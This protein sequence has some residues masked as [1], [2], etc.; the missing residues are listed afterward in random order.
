MTLQFDAPI[1][2]DARAACTIRRGTPADAE[3]LSAFAARTFSDTYGRYNDPENL[4]R[5]IAAAFHPERQADEL[6]DPAV[7]TLLAHCDDT[8][9]G[10]AQVRRSEAPACVAHEAPVELHRF[11][12]DAAW[13]GCGIAQRL[14][15]E[16]CIAARAFG[17]AVL[18]LKVWEHNARA[19]AF[20]AKSR[21]IDVGTADFQ[22][23]DDR[24]TDRVLVH[25][26]GTRP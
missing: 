19:L 20:Y 4:E 17:G 9:A 23:G 1:Q 2:R 21:F 15:G 25:P 12:V 11:Y 6:A 8:L 10:Y 7:A 22:L 24:Q 13:H 26:L 18:W 14:F 16:A 3:T 5:H